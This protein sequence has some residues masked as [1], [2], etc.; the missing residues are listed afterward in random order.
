M[1]TTIELEFAA[2]RGYEIKQAHEIWSF[3]EME[4]VFRPFFS[5]LAS[6]KIRFEKNS[7]KTEE[8]KQRFCDAVNERL[9]LT[10]AGIK[11]EP[12]LLKENSQLKNYSKL[13]L[14]SSLGKNAQRGVREEQS[15]M[16]DQS[17]VDA[18]VWSKQV[19]I[20]GWSLISNNLLHLRTQKMLN[21][22][23]PNRTCQ[24]VLGSFITA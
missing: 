1:Y 14:N 8:E 20:K 6:F 21:Y 22:A 12:D 9:S 3:P 10:Q 11:L 18:F 19:E 4:P 23:P 7:A 16:T 15:Y 17:Q 5:A 2:R 24:L 13:M